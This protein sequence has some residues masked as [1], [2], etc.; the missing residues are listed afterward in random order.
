M[1]CSLSLAMIAMVLA[2]SVAA[3]GPLRLIEPSDILAV[4]VRESRV[5]VVLTPTAGIDIIGRGSPKAIKFSFPVS[6]C[7]DPYYVSDE[8][9]QPLSHRYRYMPERRLRDRVGGFD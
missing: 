5:N 8:V 9:L 7:K 3:A 4:T 2:L 1:N 6:T